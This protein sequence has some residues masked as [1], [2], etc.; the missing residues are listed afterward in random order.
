MTRWRAGRRWL[1]VNSH[2]P[3]LDPRSY[4]YQNAARA[5]RQAEQA[6]FAET[7]P[8]PEPGSTPTGMLLRALRNEGA[9]GDID[10]TGAPS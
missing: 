3:P 2:D 9:D 6:L 1:R 8:N 4:A 5:A 7:E 10:T